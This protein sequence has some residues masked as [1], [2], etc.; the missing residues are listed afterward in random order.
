M[1]KKTILISAILV[2]IISFTVIAAAGIAF[3]F[4]SAKNTQ[5]TVIENDADSE[6]LE[7]DIPDDTPTPT[8]TPKKVDIR[9]SDINSIS[10]RTNYKAFLDEDTDCREIYKVYARLRNRKARIAGCIGIHL[11]FNRD[12]TASRNIKFEPDWEEFWTARISRQEFENLAKSIVETKTFQDWN[13]GLSIHTVNTSISVTHSKGLRQLM[14]N[15]DLNTSA[16]LS[17]MKN[18]KEPKFQSNREWKFCH[19]KSDCP[20]ING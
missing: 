20:Q 7:V 3:Y 18:F 4:L 6:D 1:D 15:V 9:V 11:Q 12:G 10:L 8:P 17:L 14:S 13:D 2:L 5:K 19:K 16:F